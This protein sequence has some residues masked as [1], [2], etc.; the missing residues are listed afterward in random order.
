MTAARPPGPKNAAMLLELPRF[1]RGVLPYLASLSRRYDAPLVHLQFGPGASVLVNHP[2]TVR[3]F[4]VRMPERFSRSRWLGELRHLVGAGLLT[5]DEGTWVDQRRRLRPAYARGHAAVVDEATRAEA[6]A[7]VARWRSAPGGVVDVQADAKRI[8][9][10]ALVR[11]MFSPDVDPDE[12]QLIADLDTLLQFVS[13]R[14][15]VVRQNLGRMGLRGRGEAALSAALGRLDAFIVDVID[16]CREGRYAAG[17]LLATLLGA[18]ASGEVDAENLHDEVGTLLLAGF[19]TTAALVTFALGGLADRPDLAEAVRAEA[20]R[21]EAGQGV[22]PVTEQVLRETLRLYPAVWAIHRTAAEDVEL[23]GFVVPRGEHVMACPYAL[24]RNPAFWPDPE[25]FRPER[26][27]DAPENDTLVGLQYLPFSHGRHTCIGK[28][29][30]LQQSR[31][32][33]GTLASAFDLA[34]VGRAPRLVPGIILKAAG[35]LPLRV[36]PREGPVR[37]PRFSRN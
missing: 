11:I 16:G 36:T 15:Q 21:A 6:E 34:R 32:L 9:L 35:G 10:R 33:V 23:G 28:R 17:L 29:M 1:T 4:L 7:A 27:A 8:L 13:F 12:R 3:Q 20:V 14:S 22:Q 26:F 18:E 37:R 24:Q 2:D 30:A 5:S 31:L 25:R 19:D